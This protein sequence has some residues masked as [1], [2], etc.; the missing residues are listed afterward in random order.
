MPRK[1]NS[2]EALAFVSGGA[3]IVL[4]AVPAFYSIPVWAKIVTL[5]FS[6]S[7]LYLTLRFVWII[8]APT[9]TLVSL[10]PCASAA[11]AKGLCPICGMNAQGHKPLT[12]SYRKPTQ[13]ALRL[14]GIDPLLFG[15]GLVDDL[16]V[17]IPVCDRCADR[18][19]HI[20]KLG[21]LAPAILDASFRVLRRKP[22]Y[23]RGLRH[24]FESSY[25]KTAN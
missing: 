7:F 19:A 11:Q 22:G 5:L 2:G 17:S 14:G 21:F 24:P 9:D 1:I 25:L 6:G 18:F 23:L 8:A 3:L 4:L 12:V 16:Q 15:E 13:S 20:S 10:K